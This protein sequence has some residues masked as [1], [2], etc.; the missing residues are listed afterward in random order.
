MSVDPTHPDQINLGWLIRL[1]W[2]M[3]AGQLATILGVR[4]LLGIAL[5]LA[6][7][8]S[9]VALEA[10][11]NVAA[12]LIA[13]RRPARPAFLAFLLALDVVLFTG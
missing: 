12:A 3:A 10:T 2:S 4:Y 13:R 8:L 7:L 6:P 1:R 9:I 5:P 11:S